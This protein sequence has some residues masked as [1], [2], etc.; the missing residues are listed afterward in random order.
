MFHFLEPHPPR[1][2][3]SNYGA[4]LTAQ[5]TDEKIARIYSQGFMFIFAPS[6]GG[7]F[8]LRGLVLKPA[9][10]KNISSVGKLIPHEI[11]LMRGLVSKPV[12]SQKHKLWKYINSKNKIFHL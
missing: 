3:G 4:E 7:L 10:R 2:L 8:I 1:T 12:F 5:H 9:F 6:S 11:F